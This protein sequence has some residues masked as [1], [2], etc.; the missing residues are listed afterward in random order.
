M[1]RVAVWIL[2]ALWM[3]EELLWDGINWIED[4][5]AFLA[6]VQKLERWVAQRSPWQAAALML[7]PA[8]ALVPVKILGLWLLTS[9]HSLA[10][11]GVILV[12]KIIGTAI[13]ARIYRLC[14][15]A[16]LSLPWFAACHSLALRI[17][18]W[19]RTT[20][21]WQSAMRWKSALRQQAHDFWTR[22]K[23]ENH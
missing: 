4:R 19:V 7:T 23:Q 14:Q 21:A 13:V 16:L 12:A 3:L 15:T 20:D 8:A 17:S 22:L 11:I 1:K 2:V 10:G 5:I 6:L 18:A 9:G